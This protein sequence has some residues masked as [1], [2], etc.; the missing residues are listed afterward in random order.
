MG[1]SWSVSIKKRKKE[2][3]KYGNLRRESSSFLFEYT[4]YV[5]GKKQSWNFYGTRRYEDC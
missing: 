4:F 2:R 5:F 3:E 1:E